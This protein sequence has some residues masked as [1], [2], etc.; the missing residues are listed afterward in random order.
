MGER[1]RIHIPLGGLL[2]AIVTHGLSR[3]ERLLKITFF[4]LTA[5][6]RRMAPHPGE[7]V[8]L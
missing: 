1:L 5:R 7:T 8:G 3:I 6:E 2:N 4:E